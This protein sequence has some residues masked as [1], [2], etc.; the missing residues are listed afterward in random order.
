MT[1]LFA[2]TA[3]GIFA[4]STMASD[5]FAG[6]APPPAPKQATG[7]NAG[8]AAGKKFVPK[9]LP[10][11]DPD[12]SGNFTTK[13]EANT[14]LERPEQFAGKRIEDVTTAELAAV[15]EVRRRKAL[16][17]APYPGGGSREKGVAIAVPIHWFDSLDT[18]NSRPWFVTDPPDGKIP[19]Q[20]DAG[21]KRS[22]DAFAARRLRGTHDSFTD[23]SVGDR[24]ISFGIPAMRVM[25]TLYGNSV[26]VLQT[27][28]Y[29][30]I[31]YEM[32]H[33][34]RIIPIEGRAGARPH[35]SRTL[36][37]YFGDAIGRWEGDTLVVETTNFNDKLPPF[38]FPASENLR[39]IERFRR[40][41]P[42]KID[43]SATME[44][45]TTWSRSWTFAIPWTEDDTQPIFEYACHEGNYGLRNILSAG[46]S[47]DKKGIKSSDAVDEQADLRIFQE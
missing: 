41:A 32:I 16:A 37:S 39:T 22:A 24:C 38:F 4:I 44:D 1:K 2:L 29:V 26:Q 47:D 13:D 30:A 31:R 43:W 18:V 40:V 14:P 34:T 5:S 28:D 3:A 35:P 27:K 9:R 12:L 19:P 10:W 8:A 20:S 7:A 17:D 25:P 15:N 46:R 33:E 45:P 11:G 21:K 6:Q 42:D 23:R 36:R